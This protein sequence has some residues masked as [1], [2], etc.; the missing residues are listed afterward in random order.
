LSSQ[1]E[2]WN[3]VGGNSGDKT[4]KFILPAPKDFYTYQLRYYGSNNSGLQGTSK[5]FRMGPVIELT[6]KHNK[7][8]NKVE[9][10]CSQKIGKVYNKAWIGMYSKG[11]TDNTKYRAFEWCPQSI[12]FS[13]K[14]EAYKTGDW[15]FRYFPT[16]ST[17]ADVASVT[18]NVKGDDR[19][20]LK[21]RE[22]EVKVI[23][24]VMSVDTQRDALWCG[25][26]LIGETDNR[27]FSK[28]R[29]VDKATGTLS[30]SAK[31]LAKGEYEARLFGNRVYEPVCKSRNTIVIQ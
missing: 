30:F 17:Y 9:I 25:L 16:G 28:Y 27:K 18:V 3:W 20:K 12:H 31:G 7:E 4:G 2:S 24:D 8:D 22:D 15:E 10:M 13:I 26:Y 11:E 5:P 6:G 19:V 29:Y 23:Y 1:Y 21:L 14:F